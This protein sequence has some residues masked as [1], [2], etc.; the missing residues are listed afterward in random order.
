MIRFLSFSFCL[1]TLVLIVGCGESNPN[2][3]IKP[4]PANSPKPAQAGAGAGNSVAPP[5]KA[6]D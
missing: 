1:S 6:I 3:Y 2:S 5:S 4:V